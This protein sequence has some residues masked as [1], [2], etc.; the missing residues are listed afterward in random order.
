MFKGRRLV[1]QVVELKTFY[2]AE[3]HHQNFCN[4]NPRNP[5]VVNV[6]MPKVEKVK[7]KLPD[8]ARS[9]SSQEVPRHFPGRGFF[10]GTRLPL[11]SVPF[12]TDK[13]A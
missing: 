6:A 2:P 4:R 13:C 7:K 8:L 12:L 10:S 1:T 5:Y 9:R 3:E 11:I